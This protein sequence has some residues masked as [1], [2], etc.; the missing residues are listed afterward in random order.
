MPLELQ[1]NGLAQMEARAQMIYEQMRGDATRKAVREGG[2][3]VRAEMRAAAPI[4]D[5]K[6][7]HSTAQEP[8]ALKGDIRMAVHGPTDGISESLVGPGSKTSHVAYWVEYGHRLVKGGYSK[9]L[10]SGRVRGPGHAIGNV[11]AHPFLRPAFET[12]KQQAL[13]KMAEVFTAVMRSAAK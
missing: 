2:K 5:H 1:I 13:D 3:I 4:L 12:T 9:L 6:T 8:G 11:P 7:A 10:K